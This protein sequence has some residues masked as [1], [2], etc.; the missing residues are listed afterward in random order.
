MS[1]EALEALKALEKTEAADYNQLK[2]AVLYKYEITPE[3]YRQRLRFPTFPEGAQP[4]AVLARL[5]YAATCLKPKSDDGRRIV[6]LIIIE[7]LL[8]VLPHRV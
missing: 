5:K 6:E 7:Q 1:G 2:K 4:R 3:T 8:S